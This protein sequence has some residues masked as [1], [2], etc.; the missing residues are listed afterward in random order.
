MRILKVSPP[1]AVLADHDNRAIVCPLAPALHHVHQLDQ[2]IG[3]GGHLV[4]L[5][6]AH[7]LEQLTGLAGRLHPRHQLRQGHNFLVDLEYPGPAHNQ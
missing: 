4:A 2:R 6:P 7:Q 3:G 5:G 1:D